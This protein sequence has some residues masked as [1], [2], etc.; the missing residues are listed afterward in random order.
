MNNG[1]AGRSMKTWITLLVLALSAATPC[2]ASAL[3]ATEAD[4]LIS[5]LHTTSWGLPTGGNQTLLG[6]VANAKV[7]E[8]PTEG[9]NGSG[10]TFTFSSAPQT[11]ATFAF[12]IDGAIQRQ[13]SGFDYTISGAVVTL[14]TACATGQVPYATYNK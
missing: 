14:S 11:N 9:C 1:W 2:L 5:S 4:S 7:Q 8:F 6:S 12:Y 13:G 10:T 3:R